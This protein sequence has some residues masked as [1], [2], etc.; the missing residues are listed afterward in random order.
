M[1]PDWIKIWG[2]IILCIMLTGITVIIIGV[3]VYGSFASVKD[4]V[5][6]RRYK[7]WV[8]RKLEQH[9]HN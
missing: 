4:F 9:D 3:A 7:R 5:E 2:E 1:M 6:E 8:E